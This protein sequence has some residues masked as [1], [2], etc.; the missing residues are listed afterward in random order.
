LIH[1]LDLEMQ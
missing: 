1:E